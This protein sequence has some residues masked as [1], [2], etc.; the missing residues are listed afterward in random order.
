MAA[1]PDGCAPFTVTATARGGTVT[2]SLHGG[3]D[4]T[5]AAIVH[6]QL[7]PV[8]DQR[9]DALV[10]DLAGLLFMDCAGARMLARARLALPPGRR[11]ALRAPRPIVLRL[12]RL[13]GLDRQFSIEPARRPAPRRPRGGPVADIAAQ[14]AGEHE[15][16]ATLFAGL[17]GTA[18]YAGPGRPDGG[19]DWILAAMWARIVPVLEVHADAAQ[20]ICYPVVFGRRTGLAGDREAAVTG[21]DDRNIQLLV[22]AILHAS[23]RRQYPPVP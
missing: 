17:E 11:P 6:R 7:G 23:G 8:L 22:T 4:S 9:P 13:T 21:L 14:I 15:R 3:L 18:R 1:E 20:E 2:I 12:L 10:F 19:P 16:I 5:T